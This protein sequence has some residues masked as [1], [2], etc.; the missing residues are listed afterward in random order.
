MIDVKKIRKDFLVY[1][2]YKDLCYL[3]S[4]ASALKLNPVNESIYNYMAY[5]GTNVHRGV[6]NYLMKQQICMKKQE[7]L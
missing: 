1:D 3:D 4:A 6:L 2:K 7:M 5:N